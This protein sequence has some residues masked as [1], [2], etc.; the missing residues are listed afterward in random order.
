MFCLQFVFISA[1]IVLSGAVTDNARDLQKI[2]NTQ[3]LRHFRYNFNRENPSVPT[4]DF[5]FRIPAGTETL[6]AEVGYVTINNQRP[7]LT[8]YR[9]FRVPASDGNRYKV[10]V[11]ANEAGMHWIVE[12]NLL[13]KQ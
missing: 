12:G 9:Y 8:V 5:N 10:Y 7:V 11:E 2:L 3:S 6:N 13:A 4:R 1:F